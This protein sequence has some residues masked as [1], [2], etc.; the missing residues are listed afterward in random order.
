MFDSPSK[1]TILTDQATDTP[2]DEF[3]KL[4]K[5]L[6]SIIE[7][8]SPQFTIGIYGEWGMGKTTLMKTIK[9]EFF[10]AEESPEKIHWIKNFLGLGQDSKNFSKIKKQEKI[11]T[12]WFNAWRYEREKA[13]ATIPLMITIIERLIDELKYVD[14]TDDKTKKNL[15]NIGKSIF[16][17]LKSCE[18]H[19]EIAIPGISFDITHNPKEYNE[20]NQIPKPTTQKGLDLISQMISLLSE[21]NSKFR[22]IVFIDDLDRCS[23]ETALNVFESIKIL[24]NIK[25]IIYVVGLSHRTIEQ[26]IQKKYESLKINGNEYIQKII[27]IPLWL[28]KWKTEKLSDF[29]SQHILPDLIDT[30]YHEII[31]G[32]EELLSFALNPNPREVKRF[33]NNF[34]FK[35]EVLK[36]TNSKVDVSKIKDVKK[37]FLI[38]MLVDYRWNDIYEILSGDDGQ[39]ND[40]LDMLNEIISLD[41]DSELYLK[42]LKDWKKS[43]ESDSANSNN[44]IRP[45]RFIRL[46]S[47]LDVDLFYFLQKIKDDFPDVNWSLYDST[48]NIVKEPRKIKKRILWVDDNPGNNKPLIEMFSPQDVTFHLCLNTAEALN[49]IYKIQN[50]I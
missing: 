31:K 22:I 29:V 49:L 6:S 10:L 36:I 4:G 32:E 9:K 37:Q 2:T 41:N 50:M 27:Q 33:V 16:S 5:I 17:F 43:S 7:G 20:N 46:F 13:Q 40:L 35:F 47:E 25:G 39:K 28:P 30:N 15:A 12:V 18:Y 48:Q 23:P 14:S 1:I 8:T 26:L 21:N 45:I 42:L 44:K 19:L 34:I 38:N 24:L 11:P 3:E